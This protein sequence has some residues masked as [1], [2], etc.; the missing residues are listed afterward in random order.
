M[1]PRG[2]PFLNS[3]AF[4]PA[5][6]FFGTRYPIDPTSVSDAGAIHATRIW[7]DQV[8]KNRFC[9]FLKSYLSAIDIV[10]DRTT[11]VEKQ[12]AAWFQIVDK[13]LQTDPDNARA[14]LLIVL[15]EL[16]LPDPWDWK[17]QY[18]HFVFGPGF[19]D[20]R[21]GLRTLPYPRHV[22]HMG[23]LSNV[24][25]DVYFHPIFTNANWSPFPTLQFVRTEVMGKAEAAWQRMG[26]NVR[27][28]PVENQTRF[29]E[30]PGTEAAKL[31]LERQSFYHAALTKK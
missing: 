17:C 30:M 15:P 11:D 3:L 27:Q 2:L 22:S 5:S 26:K 23:P 7:M 13:F 1:T 16:W 8:A 24:F 10:V 25:I 21:F 28:I 9:P 12:S 20:F 19:H 14:C 18:S 31:T 4:S 29:R 6:S